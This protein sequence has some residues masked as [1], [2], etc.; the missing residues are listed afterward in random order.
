MILILEGSA[1]LIVDF[2]SYNVH[3]KTMLC[4]S[5]YQPYLL[6]TNNA[7]TG[8]ALNFHPDF[9]CTYK[10]HNEIATEGT[11]F[12][13]I[14]RP[15]FFAVSDEQP[16]LELLKKM[17]EEME[18]E[19]TAQHE[20][21]VSYLKIFLIHTLRIKMDQPAFEG[22]NKNNDPL[23]LQRLMDS[24]EQFYRSK[25]S[26]G[27]Y[28]EILNITPNALARLVKGYF[29]KTITDLIT[30]R[31]IIEAKR[32]L[33]LTSKSVKEVAHLLGYPD[34]YYFSRFF[35]NHADVSP[36]V[37]RETVGFAKQEN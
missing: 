22:T 6:R 19:K 35:K 13:N 36:Q 37:Y 29:N 16:L 11:L 23:V 15:P 30:Q 9:F 2:S 34:E 27:D 24:I 12:H 8:I 33:Y 21:L 7:L 4:L 28:A 31:I 20:L 10:H 3:G 14:Y 17:K 32:E 26:P 25:H 18:S 5:P 1:E